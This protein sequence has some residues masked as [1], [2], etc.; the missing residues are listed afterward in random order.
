MDWYQSRLGSPAGDIAIYRGY[1]VEN[2]TVTIRA[3]QLR[4]A[5]IAIEASLHR[6]FQMI[7]SA[8]TELPTQR[9]ASH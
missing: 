6:Y 9:Y 5:N 4:T 3:K 7:S 2:V 8:A 1:V